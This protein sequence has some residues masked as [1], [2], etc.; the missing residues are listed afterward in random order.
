MGKMYFRDARMRLWLFLALFLSGFVTHGEVYAKGIDVN[1]TINDVITMG[2]GDI[3]VVDAKTYIKTQLTQESVYVNKASAENITTWLDVDKITILGSDGKSI[4]QGTLSPGYYSYELKF[5]APSFSPNVNQLFFMSAK[6]GW[7]QLNDGRYYYTIPA[8]LKVGEPDTYPADMLTFIFQQKFTYNENEANAEGIIGSLDI[9]YKDAG[10]LKFEIKNVDHTNPVT[11]ALSTGRYNFVAILTEAGKSAFP[12]GFQ[13]ST[14]GAYVINEKTIARSKIENVVV[15]AD[16]RVPLQLGQTFI[17]NK[18]TYSG[19]NKEQLE[20]E[21]SK[22]FKTGNSNA[23]SYVAKVKVLGVDNGAVVNPGSYQ[24]E[25]TFNESYL[26]K[27]K[28]IKISDAN[29]SVSEDG[30]VVTFTSKNLVIDPIKLTV[31]LPAYESPYSHNLS[32]IRDVRAAI[33]ESVKTAFSNAVGYN[34][35]VAEI[36]KSGLEIR[37]I[38]FENSDLGDDKAIDANTGFSGRYKFILKNDPKTLDLEITATGN[39]TFTASY[40]DASQSHIC[41]GTKLFVNIE[42]EVIVPIKVELP[43]DLKYTYE[44]YAKNSKWKDNIVALIKDKVLSLNRTLV[45]E[46]FKISIDKEKA[47]NEG[48][49]VGY[50]IE[51]FDLPNVDIDLVMGKIEK[52]EEGSESVKPIKYHVYNSIKL[53]PRKTLQIHFPT[54][55]FTDTKISSEEMA[56]EVKNQMILLL[57]EKNIPLNDFNMVVTVPSLKADAPSTSRNY[58]V[59]FDFSKSKVYGSV[60]SDS[61]DNVSINSEKPSKPE[62]TVNKG[63][64]FTKRKLAINFP[65]SNIP[66]YVGMKVQEVQEQIRDQVFLAIF[67]ADATYYDLYR[68]GNDVWRV[69][70]YQNGTKVEYTREVK[71]GGETFEYWVSFHNVVDV[72]AKSP[73]GV[74]IDTTTDRNRVIAAVP[75]GVTVKQLDKLAL[76]F[77]SYKDDDAIPYKAGMTVADVLTTIK[78]QLI[79]NGVPEKYIQNIAILDKD[80][81]KLGDIKDVTISI[82]EN[83][84]YGYRVSFLK[85]AFTDIAASPADVKVDASRETIIIAEYKNSIQIG[86]RGVLTLVMPQFEVPYKVDLTKQQIL[87]ELTAQ[88]TLANVPNATLFSEI[89]IPYLNNNLVEELGDNG[90]TIQ[91]SYTVTIDPDKYKEWKSVSAPG[92]VEEKG[93]ITAKKFITIKPRDLLKVT[94]PTFTGE[95][96]IPY[97]T[98]LTLESVKQTILTQLYV[99]NSGSGLGAYKPNVKFAPES[100]TENGKVGYSIDFDQELM[101]AYRG[102]TVE[103]PAVIDENNA[104]KYY[105]EGGVEFASRKDL[106]VIVPVVT[107]K[108]DGATKENIEAYLKA[109]ILQ[110]E[111]N[112]NL[113][114]SMFEVAFN[115]EI[116]DG[117]HSYTVT[118][119]KN[120]INRFK[121]I[122]VKKA[123]EAPIVG[124]AGVYTVENGVY[125]SKDG[126]SITEYPIIVSDVILPVVSDC[127]FG[128]SKT[129]IE[130]AILKQ[131]QAANGTTKD[132]PQLENWGAKVVLLYNADAA[133]KEVSELYPVTGNLYGY[134]LAFESNEFDNYYTLNFKAEEGSLINLVTIDDY[135]NKVRTQNSVNIQK[136]TLFTLLMPKFS[137]DFGTKVE[138][139]TASLTEGFDGGQSDPWTGLK[140]YMK[141]RGIEDGWYAITPAIGEEQVDKDGHVLKGAYGY[142]FAVVSDFVKANFTF[143]RKHLENPNNTGTYPLEDNQLVIAADKKMITIGAQAIELRVLT[144]LKESTHADFNKGAFAYGMTAKELAA[145]IKEAILADEANAAQLN[146]CSIFQGDWLEVKIKNKADGTDYADDEIPGVGKYSYTFNLKSELSDLNNFSI[147]WVND[148]GHDE[149][150]T[151]VPVTYTDRVEVVKE[152]VMLTMP[153]YEYLY[154]GS[155][156]FGDLVNKIQA[157]IKMNPTIDASTYNYDAVL[158]DEVASGDVLVRAGKFTYSV[159]IKSKAYSFEIDPE[160]QTFVTRKV[161]EGFPNVIIVTCEKAI[162]IRR[163]GVKVEFKEKLEDKTVFTAKYKTEKGALKYDLFLNNASLTGKALANN[164]YGLLSFIDNREDDKQTNI[165]AE[166][167]DNLFSSGA[168]EWTLVQFGKVVASADNL[169]RLLN[170][171]DKDITQ[172]EFSIQLAEGKNPVPELKSSIQTNNFVLEN[173]EITLAT[174]V[175]QPEV[176]TVDIKSEE[177]T[178]V[179]GTDGSAIHPALDYT[180][181]SIELSFKEGYGT[182]DLFKTIAP[183]NADVYATDAPVGVYTLAM[184]DKEELDLNEE[185]FE[186]QLG[187]VFEAGDATATVTV[188]Q[189]SLNKYSVTISAE[190]YYG[191]TNSDESVKVAVTA[192]KGTEAGDP[193]QTEIQNILDEAKVASWIDW[194][195]IDVRTDAGKY[196]LTLAEG[197]VIAINE[198]LTNFKTVTVKVDSLTI[199]P[200]GLRLIPEDVSI[201]YGAEIPALGYKYETVV[202][203]NFELPGTKELFQTEPVLTTDARSTS[204]RGDYRIYFSNPGEARN[205]TI[206]PEE[207][208]LSIGKTNQTLTWNDKDVIEIVEGDEHALSAYVTRLGVKFYT[209]VKYELSKQAREYVEL[210]VTNGN[211]YKLIGKNITEEGQNVKITAWVDATETYNAVAPITKEVRVVASKGTETDIRLILNN[212]TTVYDGTPRAVNAI[213]KDRAGE[214]YENLVSYAVAGSDKFTTEAPSEAG[215]YDVKVKATI[216][217]NA[218]EYQANDK[219]II[220][221]RAVEVKAE[222]F[223]IV[224]G[225]DTPDYKNAYSYDKSDFVGSV[226]DFPASQAPVIIA[227]NYKQNAGTYPLVVD[228]D[229]YTI[230]NHVIEGISGVLDVKKAPMTIQAEDK[231]SVY[232]KELE[233][234]TYTIDGFVKNESIANLGFAPRLETSAT[235]GSDAGKYEITVSSKFEATNYEVTYKNGSYTIIPA[236]QTIKWKQDAILKTDNPEGIVLSATATSGLP[237]TYVSSDEN[238][239]YINEIGGKWFLTPVQPGRVTITAYQHGNSNYFPA[240]AKTMLFGVDGDAVSNE[241]INVVDHIKVYPTLFTKDVTVLAPS[242]IKRIELISLGGNLLRVINKP[243]STIDLSDFGKGFYLLNVTLEDGTFKSVKLIKK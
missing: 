121:T 116:V 117:A 77:P 87:D 138:D 105:I 118:F 85:D 38:D 96:A 200:M 168:L 71:Q 143:K 154:D 112:K 210:V 149:F 192:P 221:P 45:E 92:A 4:N 170:P 74:T 222:S 131:I 230:P 195:T 8:G 88:L 86:E 137:A 22:K 157:D 239:A 212:V 60:I 196:K 235:K 16:E 182:L 198:L 155:M 49:T 52:V 145:K 203:M 82:K 238:I 44:Q 171:Q 33:K 161:K 97:T 185:V 115:G 5:T 191:Q 72:T 217:G 190:R 169:K 50:H 103:L 7:K 231:E 208:T 41:E 207:G 125:I 179:Y 61:Q 178:K 211:E 144:F 106:T 133:G 122:T 135:K 9:P 83:T 12:G 26:E 15:T 220:E 223:T 84:E 177:Y 69:D 173:G 98:D 102:I 204:A 132:M 184:K 13:E 67:K 19:L 1:A 113:K 75:A 40:D 227:Q 94:V 31:Q 11:G 139:I 110:N 229:P 107:V 6:I 225:Q 78:N 165:T 99:L 124:E 194:R 183:E 159:E 79:L 193:F 21:L 199:T 109:M 101:S 62:V 64:T 63:I 236:E 20:D 108:Q 53:Q 24:Y 17:Q 59:L 68:K 123:E 28:M 27:Y 104:Y 34:N 234:L 66:Y 216:K 3:S 134:S 224:Y 153:T 48:E 151:E 128:M 54:V 175:V 51:F 148:E 93:K 127:F 174:F 47:L 241:Q 23:W 215:S 189:A 140:L 10:Y 81:N 188:E 181:E 58:T 39:G 56:K 156:T 219:M 141:E 147:T 46:N 213:L 180:S 232:G 186:P 129:E 57:A 166:E 214:A 30:L 70:L 65:V 150:L 172:G 25:V 163:P 160:Q 136:N 164:G 240:E 89:D 242:A 218:Y 119:T 91:Y 206:I 37:I 90:A 120:V 201:E 233:E 73:E 202:P 167:W 146:A 126:Q 158:I 209:P 226:K 43:T 152:T 36:L 18:F 237:V 2:S 32:T 95:N 187:R 76:T 29:G 243:E 114:A 14:T 130:A 228:I 162:D 35:T 100:V 205:Y 176:I 55:A 142:T 111:A 80:G 42:H 197:A